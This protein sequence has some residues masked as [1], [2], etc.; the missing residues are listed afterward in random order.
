MNTD[1]PGKKADSLAFEKSVQFVFIHGQS[2]AFENKNGRYA[3]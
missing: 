3:K 1:S 2:F